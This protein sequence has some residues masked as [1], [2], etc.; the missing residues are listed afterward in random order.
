M[1]YLVFDKNKK[2]HWLQASAIKLFEDKSGKIEMPNGFFGQK[3]LVANRKSEHY[4]WILYIR[5]SL[6]SIF[7]LKWHFDFLNQI[8]P[9]EVFASG[10]KQKK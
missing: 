1:H 4:H 7:T 2:S 5:I 6:S 10:W 3:L 8:Y 9:K